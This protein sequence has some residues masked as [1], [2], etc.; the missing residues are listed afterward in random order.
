MAN[1]IYSVDTSYWTWIE[2]DF[3]P[4]YGVGIGYG[5]QRRE[6]RIPRR[7]DKNKIFHEHKRSKEG[8]FAWQ[9]IAGLG[10]EFTP[11]LDTSI[12]YRFYESRKSFHNHSLMLSAK[13]HF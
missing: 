6:D 3:I 8:S 5:L 9:V 10:Y 1:V 11:T 13:N 7:D 12:E 4:Y 2:N